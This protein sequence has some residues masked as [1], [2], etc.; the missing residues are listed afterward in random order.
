MTET[1]TTTMTTEAEVSGGG[2][3]EST[4]HIALGPDLGIVPEIE[5]VPRQ[6][7]GIGGGIFL[8][9][10]EGG[11]EGGPDG[12]QGDKA[13]QEQGQI[14]QGPDHGAL[15]PGAPV[16]FPDRVGHNRHSC[17]L[18]S[19]HSALALLALALKVLSESFITYRKNRRC[20]TVN[21]RISAMST[22]AMAQAWPTFWDT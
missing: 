3:Q 14:F 1:V 13:S 22:I 18:P 12:Q 8:R 6:G 15:H 7:H 19:Y 11:G 5:P 21:S 2:G 17:G 20:S 4:E 9:A 10:F 16:G